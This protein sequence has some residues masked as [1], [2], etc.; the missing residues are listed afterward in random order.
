MTYRASKG[1]ILVMMAA[2]LG[3]FAQFA[4]GRDLAHTVRPHVDVH[5]EAHEA[6]RDHTVKSEPP[7]PSAYG[8]GW[9]SFGS[10]FFFTF[11]PDGRPVT[12]VPPWVQF[13]PP[14]SFPLANPAALGGPMPSS[15]VPLA[16][17]SVSKPRRVDTEKGVQFVTLGDR[18]FRAKNFQKAGE[19]YVQAVRA[20]PNAAPQ[21]V[22][23]SQI[24]LV[25]G[26]F[27]EAAA[28]LREAVAAEPGW[29]AK[30]PD[31]QSMYAE[32]ADFARQISRL[33]S[34]VLVEPGDRDAW[35]VLGAELYFSGHT[36]R[37]SDVFVR[38]TDRKPDATLAA[39]L[40]ASG[41]GREASKP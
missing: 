32:P 8:G 1:W 40:D 18:L 15:P 39:F 28:F 30:A 34:R 11:G 14:A 13:L 2:L 20:D 27:T 9:M 37:A 33:E 24:A 16:A 6:R 31:I 19:R 3:G 10:P 35:L 22:R 38:L 29:L 36:R 21:R 23:L 25:R 7:V 5:P 17:P 4:H 26:R 12:I 41:A